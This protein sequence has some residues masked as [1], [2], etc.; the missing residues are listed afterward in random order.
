M[1]AEV[2]FG[3]WLKRQRKSIGHTQQQLALQL[4]C[5][6]ITLRKIEAEERRPSAQIAL[7]LAD[8]FNIPHPEQTAFVR[9]ARG[10]WKSAP[11]EQKQATPWQKST[12]TASSNLPA[13][14]TTLIG[15]EADIELVRS[16]LTHPGI[17]LV[18]LV[19]PPGIGKTSLSLETA[20]QLLDQFADGVFFVPLDALNNPDLI[21]LTILR[22]LDSL[23]IEHNALEEHLRD[24]I[25]T[26]QQ[27]LVLDNCEHL[28]NVAAPL[29][30]NLLLRCPRLKILITSREALRLPSEWVYPVPPLSIPK[31]PSE[32]D[33]ETIKEFPA[34]RLFTE[35]ARAVR[36]DF[37]LTTDNIQPVAAICAQLNGVPLAI[38]LIAARMRM[39][40]PDV[41]LD[42][43]SDPLILHM[44]GMRTLPS[45]Q[46]SLNN[47]I[48]WSHSLLTV[49]EQNLFARLAVFS[50]GFTVQAA[51]NIFLP[52]VSDKSIPDLIT[53]L[54]DKSLLQ[55]SW[56]EL[57]D[58]RL[59][60]LVTIQH[61][62]INRLRERNDETETRSR[63]FDYFLHLAEVGEPHMSGHGQLEWLARLQPEM[64]NLRTAFEWGLVNEGYSDKSVQ[65]ANALFPYLRIRS[66]FYEAQQW[67]EKALNL[68]NAS[69]N[70]DVYAK[71]L[72]NMGILKLLYMDI[73]A[74]EPLLLK[75][76]TIG[77]S[78]QNSKILG[79]ALDFLGLANAFQEKYE[80][81]H[82][83]FEESMSLFHSI[84]DRK[85]LALLNM[86]MGWLAEEEGQQ[87]AAYQ[88]AEQ[89]LALFEEVGD[90]LRQS[91][92]FH[93]LG[94][95]RL[96]MGELKRGRTLLKQGLRMA[97]QV[98]SKL[99]MGHVLVELSRSERLVDRFTESALWLSFAR[100]LFVECGAQGK[101]YLLEK[102]IEK[103][104]CRMD[105]SSLD[106]ALARAEAW[107]LDEAMRHA[108]NGEGEG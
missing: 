29:V 26:R 50:G 107:T 88:Y 18:T 71:A 92:L 12:P 10:D 20:R 43:L 23:E 81:A 76:V 66:E 9:F 105:L 101:I 33:L 15:R 53:S 22:S 39:M 62:A 13:A 6:T 94:S 79:E 7:R 52:T 95:Y 90:I 77:R 91:I 34:V 68:Q 8:I 85:G 3:E 98:G 30:Y 82:A 104:Q 89:A 4:S 19:G 60:M 46:K 64:S 42:R 61:F 45:R 38:E 87:N 47:A 28:I 11:I 27:L 69:E 96:S 93:I 32:L 37:S 40:S 75:S 54:L 67:L 17:R 49:E 14:L 16:Y 84:N 36:P 72:L 108:L 78:L 59:H 65:L 21:A 100:K 5:S 74:A 25:G 48:D 35:R 73:N 57:G 102:E 58:L 2:S 1:V 70:P 41:L 99:E 97:Y 44:D 56:N 55:S 106:A 86:H 80:Q 103:L 24:V 31:T 83:L 51:E 63:H